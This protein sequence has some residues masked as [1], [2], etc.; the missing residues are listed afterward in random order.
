VYVAFELSD[1]NTDLTIREAF[2]VFLANAVRWLAPP[3]RVEPTYE[4]LPPQQAPASAGWRR[5]AGTAPADGRTPLLWPGVF[6]D[7][8]GLLRAVSLVGLSPGQPSQPPAEAA[9]AAALPAP[10]AVGR[11]MELWPLLAAAAVAM[12]IAGWALRVR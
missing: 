1:D 7:E 3:G 5:L 9:A 6:R 4:H 11:Q 10:K 12:W 8:A 2:V